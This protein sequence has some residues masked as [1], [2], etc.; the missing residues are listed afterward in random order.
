MNKKLRDTLI[1]L[2]GFNIGLILIAEG[3]LL[4]K[5]FY[6]YTLLLAMLGGYIV[7]WNFFKLVKEGRLK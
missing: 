4:I 2:V 6:P 1:N 5:W 7:G 3:L